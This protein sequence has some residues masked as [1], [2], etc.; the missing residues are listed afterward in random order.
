MTEREQNEQFEK[1][2]SALTADHPFDLEHCDNPSCAKQFI[3]YQTDATNSAWAAWLAGGKS[4]ELRLREGLKELAQKWETEFRQYQDPPVSSDPKELLSTVAVSV[5][6]R[7]RA[8]TFHECA[9]KLLQL[10]LIEGEK[11]T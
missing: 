8:D 2:A 4:G 6:G 5:G 7:S 9:F 10:L 3:H 11:K 1:W